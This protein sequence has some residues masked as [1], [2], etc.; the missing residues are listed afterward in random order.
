MST[1]LYNG[2]FWLYARDSTGNISDP[3]AFTIMGVG[4]ENILAGQIRIFPNPAN[5]LITVQS[6][7]TGPHSIE[8]TSLNGQIILSRDFNGS[9]HQIDLSSFQKG[10]YFITIRLKNFVSTE[11]LI[12]L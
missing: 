10:A 11:K 1:G 6:K 12:K 2:L 5:N 9:L 8:I 7:E 3:E 4:F